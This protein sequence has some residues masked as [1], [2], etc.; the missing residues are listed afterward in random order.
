MSVGMDGFGSDT[1]HGGT[2]RRY[3]GDELTCFIVVEV[4]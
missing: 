4:N 3:C 1:V 2:G